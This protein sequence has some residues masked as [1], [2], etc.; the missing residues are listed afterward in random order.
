METTLQS[1]VPTATSVMLG[2]VRKICM[3][4]IGDL[5][6]LVLI[7]ND[8]SLKRRLTTPPEFAL[9]LPEKWNCC[10]V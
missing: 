3:T 6:Q 9:S 2:F 10:G 8:R 4:G 7:S 1:N 5:E